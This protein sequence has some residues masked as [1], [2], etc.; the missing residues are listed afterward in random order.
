MFSRRRSIACLAATRSSSDI[1]S[2][3]PELL[4]AGDMPPIFFLPDPGGR[5]RRAPVGDE[6]DDPDPPPLSLAH[7]AFCAAA[8]LARASGLITLFFLGPV[9]DAMSSPKKSLPLRPFQPYEYPLNA[10]S[11][12]AVGNPSIRCRSRSC[13]NIFSDSVQTGRQ[14]TIYPPERRA[15]KVQASRTR[16]VFIS[17]SGQ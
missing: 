14:N 8:I 13:P 9:S 12:S 5:P 15:D 17:A 11:Y 7:R 10:S 6:G 1:V 3:E 2:I 16:G 4:P